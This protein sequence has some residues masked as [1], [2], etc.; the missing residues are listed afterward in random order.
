MKIASFITYLIFSLIVLIVL[1]P[2]NTYSY[3][4]S[5]EKVPVVPVVPT[6]Y[7][8]NLQIELV[9][10]GFNFPTTM[11]FLGPN[12]FLILEKDTGLV[13]R[14]INGKTIETPL[15]QIEVSKKDERGLLGVA[16]SER[17]TSNS[18]DDSLVN[19]NDITHNVFLYAVQCEGKGKTQNCENR[20]YRYDLD[21]KNNLLVNPQI[22]LAIPSFPDSSHVGGI[23]KVGPDGNLYLTVGNFQRT[24]P[25]NLYESKSQN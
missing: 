24:V 10:D 6:V 9:A 19:N 23:V 21:N 2:G 11:E 13:K 15:L 16:V 3:G 8:Q 22:L 7:D 4:Q 1:N 17:K 18:T 20:I 14:V 12:D 5:S 25:T